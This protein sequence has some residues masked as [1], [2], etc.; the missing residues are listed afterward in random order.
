MGWARTKA[1]QE[2]KGEYTDR[3][4]RREGKGQGKAP[5]SHLI[6]QPTFFIRQFRLLSVDAEESVPVSAVRDLSGH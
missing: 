4:Q 6:G 2:K 3:I 5:H 1:D